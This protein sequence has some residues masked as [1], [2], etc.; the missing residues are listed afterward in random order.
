MP[1]PDPSSSKPDRSA[2]VLMVIAPVLLTS[3]MLVA[4]WVEGGIPPVAMAFGRWSLTFL[5]LL[6]FVAGRLWRG[7]AAIAREWPGLLVL[8][9]LGM[10]VCGAPVYIGAETTTA[11][12]IG[13]IYAASPILIVLLGRAFWGETVTVRQ[14]AGI[15]LCLSGVLTIIARGDAAVLY[16]LSF[17]VGDL[18]IV[19]AMAGW[20]LYSVLLRRWPSRLSLLV[21]FAAITLGGVLCMAPFFAA[22]MALGE[23]ALLDTRT[24]GTMLFLALIPSISAYL[25]YGRLVAVLGPSRA[26]LLMYLVPLCNAGLAWVLLGERLQAYHLLGIGLILPGLYL[27]TVTG[28]R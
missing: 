22:E 10:G 16:T 21:R 6:P 11:T 4:R 13:L 14:G 27:A 1:H 9:G 28:R 24:L 12:N 20:A 8:G 23:R 18:W 15:A 2:W 25:I 26:G 3:N 19:F 5:I 7:R 17:S